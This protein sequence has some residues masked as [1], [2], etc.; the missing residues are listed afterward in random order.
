MKLLFVCFFVF[1][2]S[3]SMSICILYFCD[4]FRNFRIQQSKQDDKTK[5]CLHIHWRNREVLL[6]VDPQSERE[7]N[8]FCGHY[9][10]G[11]QIDN[12]SE[13]Q[14]INHAYMVV[15]QVHNS[16]NWFHSQNAYKQV[17]E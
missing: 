6:L 13:R 5:Y 10:I 12:I 14:C 11:A 7:M 8:G 4:I 9:W 17:N 3:F 16:C 2:F 15:Y 1:S